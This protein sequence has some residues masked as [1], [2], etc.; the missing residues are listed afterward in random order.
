MM[1][2]NKNRAFYNGSF[3]KR[4][5]R[6]AKKKTERQKRYQVMKSVSKYVMPTEMTL[7]SAELIRQNHPDEVAVKQDMELMDH[8]DRLSGSEDESDTMDMKVGA[9]ASI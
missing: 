9:T 3:D 2:I 8:D 1:I 4:M 5:M 6:Y 7:P